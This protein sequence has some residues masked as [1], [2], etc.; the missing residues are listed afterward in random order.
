MEVEDGELMERS[1]GLLSPPADVPDQF[2]DR[3]L[4]RRRHRQNL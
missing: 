2:R 3:R 4:F 1:A